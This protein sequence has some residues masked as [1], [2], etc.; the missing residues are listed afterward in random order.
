MSL[1]RL[2]FLTRWSQLFDKIYE[3]PEIGTRVNKAY[4][5]NLVY[6]DSF[7]CGNGGDTVDMKRVLDLSPDR[8]EKITEAEPS[9]HEELGSPLLSSLD[10]WREAETLQ[11][12]ILRALSLAIGSDIAQ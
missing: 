2:I 9:I 10:F 11:P 8:M 3:T 1:V 5:K 7:R 6:K 4:T 12:K